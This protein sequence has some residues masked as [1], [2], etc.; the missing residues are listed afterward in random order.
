MTARKIHMLVLLG[1]SDVGK[2]EFVLRV[3]ISLQT[4]QKPL[5][6][7]FSV[8]EKVFTGKGIQL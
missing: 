8:L 6:T 3:R 5:L 2:S 7:Y 1:C 4:K